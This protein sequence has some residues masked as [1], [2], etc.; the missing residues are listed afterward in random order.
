VDSRSNNHRILFNLSGM[1]PKPAIENPNDCIGHV[2]G[3]QRVVIVIIDVVAL[4]RGL[5]SLHAL[6]CC[7]KS[8]DYTKKF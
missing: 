8:I 2:C 5:E 1:L 4:Y 3:M 7:A 6:L